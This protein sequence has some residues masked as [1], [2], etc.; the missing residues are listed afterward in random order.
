MST[1]WTLQVFDRA[2]C[3]PISADLAVGSG[4][5]VY[6]WKGWKWHEEMSGPDGWEGYVTDDPECALALIDAMAR[7]G[8]LPAG[9]VW[10]GGPWKD[11]TDKHLWPS[12]GEWIGQYVVPHESDAA[13]WPKV[14]TG[15][16]SEIVEMV[17]AAKGMMRRPDG[18]IGIVAPL[19]GTVA[20]RFIASKS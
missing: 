10:V 4:T 19:R 8:R 11:A 20:L 3:V 6:D 17:A 1:Q 9:W 7:D 12:R 13:G 16:R 14:V 18:A 2:R 5:G 15:W